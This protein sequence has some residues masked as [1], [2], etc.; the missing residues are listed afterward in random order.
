MAQTITLALSDEAL[1]RLER[2]SLERR[3]SREAVLEQ[4]LEG[5]EGADKADDTNWLHEKLSRLEPGNDDLE[6]EEIAAL[7]RVLRRQ[8]RQARSGKPER[9][10]SAEEA[11]EMI[12][13]MDAAQARA[14]AKGE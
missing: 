3:L 11:K 2:L 9:L 14:R 13:R 12:A 7:E 4:L 8:R 10:Y 1:N 6:P 5:A